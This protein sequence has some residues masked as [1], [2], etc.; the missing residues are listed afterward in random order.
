MK[1]QPLIF[2]IILLSGIGLTPSPALGQSPLS[3]GS[4]P[5]TP[6]PQ[7]F[8]PNEI[9]V[10]FQPGVPESLISMIHLRLGTVP[11]KLSHRG[12]A[13]LLRL[14]PGETVEETVRRYQDD[15]QVVYAE[16]NYYVYAHFEPNDP[17]FSYQWHLDNPVSGGIHMKTAWDITSGHPNVIVAVVDTGVAYENRTEIEGTQIVRYFQAPDLAGTN[18]VAGYD[19]VHN[20]THANDDQAHGTHVTG[21][22]AQTT[23]NG[24]GVA[25]VAFNVTI[26][27]VK[28]LNENGSGSVFDV[29]D[30]I[31]FAA[32]NG[33]KVI[34]LSL[35][36]RFPSAT[37]QNAV[38]YSYNK[39]VTNVCSSG[40]DGGDV[41]YPAK[42]DSYCIAV[43]ATRFDEAKTWYSNYG[44]SL[45]LMA[46]GGDLN[47][48]QNNDGYGDGVLQQTFGD[49]L[50]DFGYFF[51][52]GT[53]MSSPHVSGV[54]AL[55]I[56]MDMSRTPDQ[57][58]EILQNSA[59][60]LGP[61]GWDA[62]T[63]WGLV[64]AYAAL[65]FN[66][67]PNTPPVANPGGPYV[68]T[69]DVAVQFDG[70]ASY[71]TDGDPLAYSWN[72][73]DGSAANG[74]NPL[75]IYTA[76][77]NYTV[78]LV[79]NDG[80]VNS[81]P[82]TTTASIDEVN[83]PPVANPGGPYQGEE[84]ATIP[85]DGS[86]SFD[87]EGQPLT[88]NWDFGDGTSAAGV[89]PGHAYALAD[90]YTVTLTVTDNAGLTDTKSTTATVVEVNDPPVANPGGPYNG[91]EDQV[92][93]F[94]GSGSY[95]PEVQPLSYNWTFGDGST[96]TG[97]NPSHAYA[98]GG[99][100]TVT[101][102]VSD[103][104][105][106]SDPV[107]TTATITDVN[108]S[109]V[110]NPGGPYNGQ[111]DQPIAFDGSGSLDPDGTIATYGW[112]FGDGSSGSGINPTH[113]YA[114]PG[115]YT[116]SLTVTDNGGLTDTQSTT[117]TV[118]ETPAA[119]EVFADSFEN[120]EWNGKWTEDSQNDWLIST[121]RAVD[122]TR[123]AE[124]DGFTRDGQIVSI[125]INLKGR[126]NA[127]VSFYWFMD[128][129]VDSG[130]YLAFDVST[131]GG[132]TW[133][134]TGIL[135][136]DVSPEGIWH[137]VSRDLT[138]IN[139][140]RLRFRARAGLSNEDCNVDDVHVVAW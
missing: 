73:G 52:Q 109:P 29:A 22:I 35:G 57:V 85:F 9:I 55:L 60:D 113:T 116:V 56:S 111:E 117:A 23:H 94:D 31:T 108:D 138:G 46:P 133:T 45:D 72:F 24:L 131:N 87:P 32:D 71:D 67:I 120:G 58:R 77:G 139:S 65:I 66:A 105:Q 10:Q 4:S 62:Q 114:D 28:V 86:G 68:G 36:S 123:S 41:S 104:V 137:F 17:F 128:S 8:V 70:I 76:G 42:Y 11:L 134:Q 130:E 33:A 43:G 53:S 95:D 93:L 132:S 125:P 82:A 26:M 12:A 59:K 51:Y 5:L 49:A 80:K 44:S 103:G 27:P 97:V 74:V 112:D 25:G 38:R 121:L 15:P 14:R 47:V 127:T 136:G 79:V 122:G 88:Y 63:G 7:D 18:F 37:I 19:F 110:A 64:D 98:S 21:T 119:I 61:T 106:N 102:V 107:S 135:Q 92:I 99:T 100:Y 91:N 140:L 89:N 34:N 54:A 1:R 129:N 101:L 16:P 83:D 81:D 78:T 20:D 115:T 30:G 50:D 2:L 90:T 96:G 40:N 6:S 13:R 75:H 39:G 126:T 118:A 69:E 3:T 84:G 48:D 124:V